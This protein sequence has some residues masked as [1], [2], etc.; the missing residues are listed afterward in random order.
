[1]MC[2]LDV[3]IK[4]LVESAPK[5]FSD[6]PED[7]KEITAVLEKAENVSQ[8]F[9]ICLH[10]LIMLSSLASISKSLLP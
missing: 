8:W 7:I 6:E 10:S 9:I 2:R 1:M 3:T 5:I 4:T